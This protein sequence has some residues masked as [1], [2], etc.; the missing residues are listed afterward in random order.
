MVIASCTPAATATEAP[1]EAVV[2]AA[3]PTPRPVEQPTNTPVPTAEASKEAPI[4]AAKV[5]SGELPALK[6]RLPEKPLTLSPVDG[7]GKYGGRLKM[8]SWWQDGG[9]QAKMYGHSAIRFVD[10]GLGLAPGMCESW[11]TNADNT[12]WTLHWR[13]GLKWSDGSPCTTADTIYWWKDMVIDPDQSENPPAEFSAI[14]GVLPD[15]K[16]VDDYTL[17]ITYVK[18]A[19]LT[20]KRLAMWVH[21]SIGPRWIV[22]SAY[23]KKFNPKYN[24]QYTDYKEHDLKINQ[25]NN[26]ECPSLN[27]WILTHYEQ[28]VVSTYDRNPYYYAV[29]IGRASCRERV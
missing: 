22:P 24:T 7:T 19:P 8:A 11:E 28:K 23:A 9:I 5:A 3:T 2:A 1:T 4:L 6:D 27:S 20:G 14:A 16:A 13:K 25:Q 26:P 29:E 12:V 18:S 17:T 21:S 10:D 15:F